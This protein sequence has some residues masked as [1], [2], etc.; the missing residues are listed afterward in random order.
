MP[1]KLLY[2]PFAIFIF[3]GP[4]LADV[5]CVQRFLSTTA[6]D[7]GPIDGAWGRKT[8]FALQGLIEQLELEFNYEISPSNSDQF[9]SY[10]EGPDREQ[11]AAQAM[12]RNYGVSISPEQLSAFTG[13]AVVDFSQ[14]SI[15]ND[16]YISCRFAIERQMRENISRIELMASGQLE[17]VA[18]MIEFTAHSWRTRGLAS[19]EYLH[20]EA[21]L[22]VDE[23]GAVNGTMPYFHLFINDGEVALP[24]EYVQ[25]P[26]EYVPDGAYPAGTT[27]FDVDDW[28]L[29]RLKIHTCF[30][31]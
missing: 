13:N 17:I 2:L 26:R 11:V 4:A 27:T 25:L 22:A 15:A 9:C 21:V 8:E 23:E 16:L 18:G 12:V 14:I 3:S 24:P 19:E 30:E 6:F 5:A 1:V 29:G 31:S 10:F 28:Q 7:P 20:D